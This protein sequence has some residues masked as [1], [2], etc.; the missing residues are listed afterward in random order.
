MLMNSTLSLLKKRRLVWSANTPAQAE[1]QYLC[2]GYVQLDEQLAGGLPTQGVVSIESPLGI[3]ELR[4]LLPYLQQS[5][6]HG[7]LLVIIAPPMPI[8]SELLA[9]QGFALDQILLITPESI[10][11][12]L[13]SA[14]QCLKSGCCYAVLM[15][16]QNLQI[17]QVKRLQLAAKA[18]DALQVIFRQTYTR[19]TPLPVSLA[20]Q[21]TSQEQ[22]IQVTIRK[23][24]GG[25]PSEPFIVDMQQHWPKLTLQQPIQPLP[26][27]PER[28]VS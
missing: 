3:G 20:L 16:Q 24:K 19:Q 27:I 2:S 14:E 1:P 9:E 6:Q 26:S 28:R 18:G 8:N 7:R 17:H 21:L 25:W 12:A 23:R 15:W 4:L 10:Q 5:Q 11:Q 22:G 13:W